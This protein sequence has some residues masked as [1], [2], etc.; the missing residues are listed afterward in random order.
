MVTVR[1]GLVL[2]AVVGIV[3]AGCDPATGGEQP[4]PC[5]VGQTQACDC[6]DGSV[7]AQSC[8]PDGTA[9]GACECN[10]AGEGGAGGDGGAGVGVGG[11]PLGTGGAEPNG[12]GGNASEP[13]CTCACACSGCP[14]EVTDS[15]VGASCGDGC[16]SCAT[17][18]RDACVAL[19]CTAVDFFS[20]PTCS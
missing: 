15:T 4:P 11:G 19:Q 10:G 3:A 2:V 8:L 13:G 12:T 17:P 1:S 5:V 18:C 6:P 14:A 16:T 7:S 20:E 9:R